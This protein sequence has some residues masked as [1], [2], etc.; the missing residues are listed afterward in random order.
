MYYIIYFLKKL[1]ISLFSLYTSQEFLIGS[2]HD[3]H[4]GYMNQM[5]KSGLM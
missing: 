5:L 3:K 1:G 2:S 4:E